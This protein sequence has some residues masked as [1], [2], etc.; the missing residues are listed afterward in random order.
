MTHPSASW[1][2]PL[3]RGDSERFSNQA[4]TAQTVRPGEFLRGNDA[5]MRAIHWQHE[6]DLAFRNDNIS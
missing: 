3:P 6:R 5:W 2:L 4:Y 1:R